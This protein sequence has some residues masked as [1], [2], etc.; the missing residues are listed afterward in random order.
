ML[1][2]YSHNTC[3]LFSGF[4]LDS[5]HLGKA[6]SSNAGVFRGL[7]MLGSATAKGPSGRTSSGG[8]TGLLAPLFRMK[9]G[10]SL[11]VPPESMQ[12]YSQVAMLE[13]IFCLITGSSSLLTTALLAGLLL[14]I[15]TFASFIALHGYWQM[16]CVGHNDVNLHLNGGRKEMTY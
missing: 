15:M 5:P 9:T 10:S 12:F 4:H 7:L 11:P 1:N 14:F 2:D 13:Y 8:K 6:C 3:H 16:P